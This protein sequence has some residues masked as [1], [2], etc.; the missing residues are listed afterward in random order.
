[1]C[2]LLLLLS[3][4]FC[5][6]VCM[7]IYIYICMLSP[8]QRRRVARVPQQQAGAHARLQEDDPPGPHSIIVNLH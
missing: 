5:V 7:Y 3:L 1:M 2:I 6:C 8:D 4:L